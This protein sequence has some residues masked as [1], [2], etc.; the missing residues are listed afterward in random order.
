MTTTEAQ[1]PRRCLI[2][3]NI[4]VRISQPS[5]RYPH[6]HRALERLNESG[7]QLFTSFQNVAEYWNVSTRPVGMNGG[8]LEIH[9]VDEQVRGFMRRFE[10]VTEDRGTYVRWLQ[11]LVTHNVSGRQVHDARL[12]A[13]MLV[14]NIPSLLTS[15]IKDFTRY[16][17]IQLLD[18]EQMS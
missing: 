17:E 13:H 8:G 1:M 9:E 16:P 3:T 18:P 7:C 11:L 5:E 6:H 10:I 15:N 12:V 2:D 4:L 14:R